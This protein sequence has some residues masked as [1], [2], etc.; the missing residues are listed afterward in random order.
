MGNETIEDKEATIEK[1]QMDRIKMMY[2]NEKK[3]TNETNKF[4]HHTPANRWKK[5]LKLDKVVEING[6]F[7][8]IVATNPKNNHT[9]SPW[10]THNIARWVGLAPTSI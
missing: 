1:E 4:T 3:Q 9:T 6:C 7:P 2:P 8:T 10:S 5:R